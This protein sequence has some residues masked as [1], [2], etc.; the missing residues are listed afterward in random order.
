MIDHNK[1]LQKYGYSISDLSYGSSRKIVLTCDYCAV[2]F[3]KPYKFR[4]KQ[5]VDL[6]K[7]CC[8]QCKFKKREELSL[9]KY[10]V[11]N[12]SQREDVKSKLSDYNI[13]DYKDSI[14]E[15]L[16]QGYSIINIASKLNIP[17]TSLRRYVSSL[18]LD[19]KGN[20]QAKTNKTLQEK[21]GEDYQ[22]IISEK[23]KQTFLERFGCDNPF[24]NE[25]VK[26]KIIHTCA[27]KYGHQHHMQS[28]IIKE[29]VKRTNLE[30]YG[31]DNVSKIPEVKEK[32]KETN[33]NKYG[34][35]LATQNPDIKAKIV[36]TMV[37]NGNA[38][39]FDG[40]DA[41][42]WAEKTGYCLSRFNQLV[43]QYGFEIAKTMYRTEGYSALELRF[44]S[45]LEEYQIPYAQQ[46][47]VYA[48]ENK[49]YI[50]DFKI[51]NDLLIECDGLYWH[52]ERA[53]EDHKYHVNKQ[54]TYAGKGYS[55]LFFREDE[56]RDRFEIVKSILLNK[57]G[58]SNT[59]YARKC[60][61]DTLNDK[62][63]DIFFED[64]HLMGKGRG[65]TYILIHNNIIVSALRLK[66]MKNNTF[67]IS[68]FCNAKFSSVTGGFSKLL[69]KAIQEIRPDMI[70]T[71]IDKRYGKG[72]YLSG[73]GFEYIHSYPSFKWTDGVQTYHRLQFPGNTGYEHNLFKL[74][75]CGQAKWIL[76]V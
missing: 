4:L 12:S 5:N 20:I 54:E 34:F 71:F 63:A 41:K 29:K 40:L 3:D 9:L 70:I 59:I 76:K 68:R 49:Y 46:H 61:I 36:A 11:K 48:D 75:D 23:R 2:S 22:S 26:E 43:K 28:P 73:L 27:A 45:L 13:D 51:N 55:S 16:E 44:R 38:R 7:D 60:Q 67:E 66:R 25:D 21:Y 32:I 33:L 24:A 37:K 19:T 30:K 62:D 6:D 65:Q 35:A 15:L 47:R 1:T 10:G 57:L 56:L 64:N 39:I 31:Y 53:R 50:A 14:L 17:K 69:K 8:G 42:A 18:G 74:W 72:D 58:E 52:S